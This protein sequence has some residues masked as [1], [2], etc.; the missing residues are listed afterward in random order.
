MTTT[1][2]STPPAGQAWQ[3]ASEQ[4]GA[5]NKDNAT[6]TPNTTPNATTTNTTPNTTTT[7]T[8]PSSSNYNTFATTTAKATTPTTPTHHGKKSPICSLCPEGTL[9]TRTTP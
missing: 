1:T 7:A 9:G 3:L 4:R 5:R 6:T 2:A 8:T